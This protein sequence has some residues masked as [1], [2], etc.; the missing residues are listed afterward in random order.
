MHVLHAC[1]HACKIK[2][3]ITALME[4]TQE[5]HQEIVQMLLKIKRINV[6]QQKK[7][8]KTALMLASFHVFTSMFYKHV[9]CM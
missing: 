9:T 4:A 5:G 2:I 3:S 6:N 1:K 7:D 8:G